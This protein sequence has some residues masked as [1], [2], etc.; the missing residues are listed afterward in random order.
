[1]FMLITDIV[2]KL[3]DLNNDESLI[4][5]EGKRDKRALNILGLTNVKDISGK[6]LD[7][8]VEKV[9]TN[10]PKSVIIL[11]D[12]DEEGQKK[13]AQLTKLLQ[14]DGIEVNSFMRRYI[15]KLLQ[16]HRIEEIQFI[17]LLE[18]DYYGK[19]C[20]INNKIFNRS[21][22]LMR[23]NSRKTRRDRGSVRT[24]RGVAGR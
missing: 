1:M 22:V 13:E 23:R 5:V 15:R 24:N 11:S 14:K 17:K 12:F 19:T 6:P 21:R 2:R 3:N 9:K 10:N 4:I 8:F 16:I 7:V 20:S 18:D